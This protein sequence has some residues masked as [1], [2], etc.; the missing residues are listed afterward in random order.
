MC[1]VYDIVLNFNSDLY[2]FFEWK[3]EDSLYHIKRINLI[4]VDSITYNNIFDNV[5]TFTNNSF[6]LNIFNKCEYY[7]NRSI[8]TINYAFIITDSYRLLGIM[9][10]N[11]GKTI[12][13]SSFLLDEEEE[14][15]DVSNKL[16]ETKLN[17]KI[18]KKR[19]RNDFNTRLEINIVNFIKNDLDN[20]YKKN[21]LNKLKYLYY[22]YF[23]KQSDNIDLIYQELVNELDK[24]ITE[25]HYN[26]Y[27]LIK[28]SLCQKTR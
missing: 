20:N 4:K 22:E 12:K 13:Y 26:L 6:L 9:L 11:N 19:N 10:D 23:N 27:N 1:Y 8:D 14:I 21:N 2:E 15:L 16:K 5:V 7:T 3:R 28:L 25:K 17:Y 18:I 24:D